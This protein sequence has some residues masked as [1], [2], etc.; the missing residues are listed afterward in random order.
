MKPLML[1][2]AAVGVLL[3][4]VSCGA[5][6]TGNIE[7][8]RD[9]RFR[10][11]AGKD[12]LAG[13]GDAA[14]LRAVGTNGTEPFLF[15]WSVERTPE[16][17][18][19]VTLTNETSAETTTSPLNTQGR[20]V[21]RVV[22]V[23]A[24][25]KDA[26]SFVTVDVGP[27]GTGTTTA[28][29]V[30]IEGPSTIAPGETGE[31]RAMVSSEGEF[32][33]LWEVV[34]DSPVNFKSPD[35]AVTAFT[36]DNPGTVVVRVTVRDEAAHAVGA[37][38]WSIE[39]AIAGALTVTVAG[40]DSA[41]L[42]EVFEVT[43]SVSNSNGA[44]TYAW[45]VTDGGAELTN[46][47][48]AMVSVRPTAV[49]RLA[50][51]VEVTDPLDGE[52]ATAEYV[53]TVN[54]ASG[55]L[56]VRATGPDILRVGE[57]GSLTS[58]VDG[59]AASDELAY[60][61]EI[62]SGDGH[63]HSP[64]QAETAIDATKGETLKVHLRVTATGSEGTKVGEADVFVVT[65]SEDRPEVVLTITG[66]GEMVFE[67]RADVAP[68]SVANFLH[69]VD[70]GFYDGLVIHRVISD[71]VIQG[72]GYRPTADGGLEPV[73]VRDPVS[74]EADNG[75]SNV[76]GTVAMA[77]RGE[78]VDSGTSQWFVNLVDNDGSGTT[79][80]LDERHFTVFAS[81]TEG[82]EVV[83][84]IAAVETESRPE[85]SGSETSI[86]VEDVVIESVVRREAPSGGG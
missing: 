36:V 43:A 30:S 13:E 1:G 44:V 54:P 27:P 16:G 12:G 48:G 5:G 7:K 70:D 75:L 79:T 3:S 52:T 81:V 11:D 56:T 33:Y 31:L 10:A 68:K 45:T 4:G 19:E 53:V 63:L 77:L 55:T 42:E 28:L 66:F 62:V 9:Q 74:G 40:P 58:E 78:D 82:M 50:V 8:P 34:T 35:R 64:Q 59:A 29:E 2:L 25:G 14:T 38:E 49:G 39:A 76:R 46:S 61:W 47:N 86:P 65:I 85:L 15:R 41:K 67:L 71:F 21:F 23:D 37:A 84:A 73:D 69:Y 72:G 6:G 18:A 60:T 57:E 20:Y 83:E 22:V 80:N 51:Q 17:A 24:A 26:Y 32:T